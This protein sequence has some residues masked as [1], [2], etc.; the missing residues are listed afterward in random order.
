MICYNLS[1]AEAKNNS[2]IVNPNNDAWISISE[3]D[4]KN[5]VRA[6]IN[7]QFLDKVPTLKIKFWD[8]E[9]PVY[10]L[11]Q[12]DG[13]PEMCYPASKENIKE[14]VDFVVANKDKNMYVNCAAGKS[15]SSAVCLFCQNIL[16]YEWD[17]TNI[18]R[19]IPNM[20]VYGKMVQYYVTTYKTNF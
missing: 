6:H 17:K 5:F 10:A 11:G 19:A 12:E 18:K 14:L 2:V 3:P 20:Y 1:R 9:F 16:G 8:I 13:E 7:N 4:G 15:R